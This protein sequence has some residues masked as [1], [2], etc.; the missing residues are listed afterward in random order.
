VGYLNGI[1]KQTP[2]WELFYYKEEDIERNPVPLIPPPPPSGNDGNY[3][4]NVE[5][6]K[7]IF[8]P[9]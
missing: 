9:L 6:T 2:L 5:L 7:A 1:E 4:P 3:V 8:G